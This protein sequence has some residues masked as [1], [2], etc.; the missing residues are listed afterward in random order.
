[1]EVPISQYQKELF[2]LNMFPQNKQNKLRQ[3]KKDETKEKVN[4]I[5]QV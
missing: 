3:M 4:E 5:M 2:T 1:M